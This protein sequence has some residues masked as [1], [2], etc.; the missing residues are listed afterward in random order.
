MLS[1]QL[2]RQQLVY[3]SLVASVLG[4]R[5]KDVSAL[6]ADLDVV[7]EVRTHPAEKI[8]VMVD[9]QSDERHGLASELLA[10]REGMG[11]EG[12]NVLLCLVSV[13]LSSSFLTSSPP[14]L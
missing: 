6:P 3:N 11:R 4:R 10:L 13:Q 5:P 8:T 9:M 7:F 2:L 1:M 12:R 14:L